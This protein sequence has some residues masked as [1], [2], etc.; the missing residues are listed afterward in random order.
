MI[1]FGSSS[2]DDPSEDTES[3]L[4][5]ADFR[6]EGPVAEEPFGLDTGRGGLN[7]GALRLEAGFVRFIVSGAPLS[8]L[9]DWYV[10]TLLVALRSLFFRSAG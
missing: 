7:D 3:G 4:A 10:I 1:F 2:E 6:R 5:G 9:M 8:G